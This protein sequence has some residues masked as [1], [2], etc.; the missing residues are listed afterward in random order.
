MP[1]C[2]NCGDYF[3]DESDNEL[4]PECSDQNEESNDLLNFI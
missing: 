2:D 1:V 4:C 3:E